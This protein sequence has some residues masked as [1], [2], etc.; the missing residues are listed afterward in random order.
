MSNVVM[1]TPFMIFGINDKRVSSSSSD[2]GDPL[3]DFPDHWQ[4]RFFFEFPLRQSSAG[5]GL[6]P[7]PSKRKDLPASGRYCNS[8]LVERRVGNLIGF[9]LGRSL[10]HSRQDLSYFWIGSAVV[11]FRVLCRVRP[12]DSERHCSAGTTARAFA[13]QS[14][15]CSSHGTK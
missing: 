4:P 3:D 1:G 14:I 6:S 2:N 9:N 5:G 12:P 10:N 8:D 15:L 13:A 11:S 7:P